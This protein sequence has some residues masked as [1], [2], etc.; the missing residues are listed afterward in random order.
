MAQ[1]IAPPGSMRH[2]EQSDK[3]ARPWVDDSHGWCPHCAAGL[4]VTDGGSILEFTAT[5]SQSPFATGLSNPFGLAVDSQGNVYVA[6]ATK[7]YQ[8]TPGGSKQTFASGIGGAIGLTFDAGGN[9]YAS[10]AALGNI[11]K[12]TPTGSVSTYISLTGAFNPAGLAFTPGGVLLA[13]DNNASNFIYEITPPGF[14]LFSS[15]VLSPFGLA[16]DTS[17]DLFGVLGTIMEFSPS[18]Q[19]STFASGLNHP[20][21]IAFDDSGNLFEADNGTGKIYEFT[22]SG[23]RTTFA[24]NLGTGLSGPH[25]LAFS[26]PATPEPST[27]A[28]AGISLGVLWLI[29][30][31]R[32][33]G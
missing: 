2:E 1:A 10:T 15:S 9:L 27:G 20:E 19:L 30:R 17:G 26:A 3:Q 22:P 11:D 7:I 31:C 33:Y 4:L 18:G 28:L 14:S 21:G 29:R 16:Y 25:F 8:F 24:S 12:I 13:A 5:G 6:D 32:R 23:S